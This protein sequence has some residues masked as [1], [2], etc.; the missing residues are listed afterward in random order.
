MK[1]SKK[2]IE[3]KELLNHITHRCFLSVM[4]SIP[5]MKYKKNKKLKNKTKKL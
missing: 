3:N 4:F 5:F 1:K 2:K